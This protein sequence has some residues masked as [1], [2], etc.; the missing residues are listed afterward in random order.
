MDTL[1]QDVTVAVR[2]LSGRPAFAAVVVATLTLGI[3]ATSALFSVVHGVLLRPLPYPDADR[4]VALWQTAK[5]DP[6][7]TA[8]GST[9]HVNFLDWKRD[10]RSFEAMA[11]FAQANFNVTGLGDAEIVEGGIVTPDFFR[12]FRSPPVLGREFGPGDDRPNS[13][14]VVVVSHGFWR[15]RLG[16][17]PDVLGTTLEISGTSWEIVG[18]A[19]AGFS[20][21]GKARLWQ[22]V[23]NDDTDCGRGCVYLDGVGRLADGVTLDGARREMQAL[24]ERLERDFPDSNTNVTIGVSPLQELLVGEVRTPLLILLGAVALL[25]LIACANVANLLLVR[26]AARQGEM[27]LRT[28]LGAGRGRLLRF[29]LTESVVLGIAGAFGGLLL[30]WWAVDILKEIAP[31]DVPRLDDVGVDGITFLFAVSVSIATAVVFG[32]GP[33]LQAV[34]TPVVSLIEARS[35]L[36]GRRTRWS[37]TGL[38]AAEVALSLLLLVAAGLLLRSLYQRQAVEPGWRA[39]GITVFT[40]GLPPSRYPS[41]ADVVRAAD[42]IDARLTAIPGVARVGRTGAIPLGPSEIV[43]EFTRADRPDPPAGQVP[44]AIVNAVDDEYFAVLGIPLAAGRAFDARDAAGGPLTMIVSQEMADR[45]WRGEDPLGKQV[46]VGGAAERRT[47][48]G[49]AAG[50]R[51]RNLEAPPQP[52]MY[53]PHRQTGQRSMTFVVA[54]G[55]P[56]AQVLAAARGVLRALDSRLPMYR[57]EAF[58]ALERRALARPRFYLLLLA[59]FA[60][61]AIGLAGVGIYGVVAYAVTRRT[62]EIGLRMA[63]GARPR[64]VIRLVVWQG[65]RPALAGAALGLAG[66]LAAGRVIAGLLFQVQPRDPATIAAVMALV[67]A[68]VVAACALPAWRATRIPPSSALRAE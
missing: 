30:A 32:L 61:L 68:V 62:R 5:D 52:E 33:A 31:A 47:I 13:P 39:E 2:S 7:P 46:R 12:T 19:A 56:A 42:E 24:A 16:G 35:E 67:L 29:L 54:S 15:E 34:S 63:L 20:F 27:A 66:A 65:I 48:V 14:R 59:L 21:P 41:A 57:A 45:H 64:E 44:I 28:A 36:G 25:L 40:T 11:L 3:G 8:G 60:A 50:V 17:R 43:L 53:L 51:S 49:V 55:L 9:S 26:G 58:D 4:I 18:V 37:R 23:R 38:L 10:A 1:R 22:P 6:Q